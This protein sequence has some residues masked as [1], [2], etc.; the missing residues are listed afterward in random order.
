MIESAYLRLRGSELTVAKALS[1]LV[2]SLVRCTA[3]RSL[4]HDLGDLLGVYGGKGSLMCAGACPGRAPNIKT[5]ILKRTLKLT[6]NSAAELSVVNS[7]LQLRVRH[8]GTK[9]GNLS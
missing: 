4:S 8:N 2:L 3:S 5:R 9:L 1:S 6:W 7:N